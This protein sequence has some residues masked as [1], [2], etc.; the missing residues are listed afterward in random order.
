MRFVKAHALG[1]DFL[2]VENSAAPWAAIG[3]A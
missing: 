2:L 1:N 3:P